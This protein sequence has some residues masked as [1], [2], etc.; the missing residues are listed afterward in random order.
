M[1]VIGRQKIPS[2]L[3]EL[4]HHGGDCIMKSTKLRVRPVVAAVASLLALPTAAYA[5]TVANPL[6]PTNRANFNP[7]NGEDIVVP[8][9]FKV[10]VLDSGLNFPTGLAFR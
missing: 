8:A 6:C 10:S 7:S 1:R 2:A 3:V 5:A 4:T 9:G